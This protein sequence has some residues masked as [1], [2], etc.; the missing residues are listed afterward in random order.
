MIYLYL[1]LGEQV[2]PRTGAPSSENESPRINLDIITDHTVHHSAQTHSLPTL[3]SQAVSSIF[4]HATSLCAKLLLIKKNCQV[5]DNYYISALRNMWVAVQVSFKINT[6]ILLG[7]Y[8]KIQKMAH[9]LF[10]QLSQKH[11][12]TRHPSGDGPNMCDTW[13]Q[14]KCW[15]IRV[16]LIGRLPK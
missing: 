16:Q 4:F 7:L 13:S 14:W 3:T 9:V 11:L 2:Q 10:S 1:N 8:P 6:A 12:K 5:L 15:L